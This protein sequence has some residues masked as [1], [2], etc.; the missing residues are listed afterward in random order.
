M[1]IAKK[2]SKIYYDT[3]HPASFSNVNKL[4]LAT[5]KKISKKFIADWLSGQ[6]N[7]T[8]HRPRQLKFRRNCYILSNI[9]EYWEADL[10]VFPSELTHHNDNFKYILMVIDCFSKF[11]FAVPL[12]RKT[13]EAIITGFEEIF[14]TTDRRCERLRTDRGGEFESAKFKKL[15]KQHNITY[16]TTR[17]PDIKCSMVE[18][19]IRT[20]K[21]KIFKYLAYT[22]SLRYIDVLPNIIHSYNNT[23]HRT[24]KMTP[25]Q[26]NDKNILQVYDN[27]RES[28]KI[29]DR[30]KKP[31]LKIGDYIRITKDKNVF[32]KGYLP[33][34]T[35]E[36]FK[37]SA[38]VNRDP[39]VYRIVDLNGEE[40]EGTF[41][42]KEVQKI[43]L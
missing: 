9:N 10:I 35:S 1:S 26:V 36:P 24:I 20:I 31:K 5:E 37:I 25:N 12:K 7:Y 16:S 18:R 39:I 13:T 38:V 42:E 32:Q 2:L 28:Q 22:E 15:M 11:L 30:K 17:N 29:P 3:K 21:G 41:Y 23:Y 33:N 4:W 27:I 34:W 14:N 40:I 8:L 6:K 19:C 43:K